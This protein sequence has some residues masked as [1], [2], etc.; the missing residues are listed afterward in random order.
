MLD[1]AIA[2]T[3]FAFL[4]FSRLAALLLAPYLLWTL[5]ATYLT[6]GIAVLNA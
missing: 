2:L 3:I 4:K 6:I 1:I 5:F